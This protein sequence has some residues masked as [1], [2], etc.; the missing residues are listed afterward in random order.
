MK[1]IFRIIRSAFTEPDIKNLRTVCV[2][3]GPYRNLTTLTASLFS[4][5]PNVQ[6]LNHAGK[7]VFDRAEINFIENYSRQKLEAFCRFAVKASKKGKR[8]GFGGSIVF[9]HAFDSQELAGSYY[10]RFG[11][12]LTKEDIHCIVWK[13]S[14]RVTNL[15]L[16]NTNT[17]EKMVANDSNLRFLLPVRHPLDCAESNLNTKKADLLQGENLTTK[18]GVLEAIFNEFRWFLELQKKYP[19]HFLYFT[20]LEFTDKKIEE[21]SGFL[22]LPS[23]AEWK[24]NVRELFK[25]KR[26]YSHSKEDIEAALLSANR[27]FFDFPEFKEDIIKMLS[28]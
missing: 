7:R 14:Q 12:N 23:D 4:L 8:G 25:V 2:L 13:E 22:D 26:T 15:L 17:I 24:K 1:G 18:Q 16:K 11:K 6:V 10:K 9:S 5:H 20:E 21:L 27:H 3:L 19:G 28:S